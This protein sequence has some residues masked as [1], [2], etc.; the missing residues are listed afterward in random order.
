MKALVTWTLWAIVAAE[1]AIGG[2]LVY[3]RITCGGI[4]K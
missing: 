4:C 1:L 2:W 3:A